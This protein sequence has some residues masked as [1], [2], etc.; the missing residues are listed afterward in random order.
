MVLGSQKLMCQSVIPALFDWRSHLLADKLSLNL[1]NVPKGMEDTLNP[2]GTVGSNPVKESPCL[3]LRFDH[4][5]AVVLYPDL[6]D[7]KEY[8]EMLR[9]IRSE[10]SHKKLNVKHDDLPQETISEAEREKLVALSRQDPLA[11]ISEQE[12]DALWKLRKHCLSIPD[13]LP[14]FLDAVKWNSRDDLTDLYVLLEEW[15]RVSPMTALELLDCKYADPTVRRR[16]VEWLEGMSDEDLAQYLLQLVQTLKYE[17]VSERE[18][19]KSLLAINVL[20]T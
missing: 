18:I 14:R 1:W 5:P 17:P 20:P 8:A 10:P 15:P 7:F 9:G 11:E 16:A 4:H 12:K 19:R 2:L 6:Q 13:I 3:E